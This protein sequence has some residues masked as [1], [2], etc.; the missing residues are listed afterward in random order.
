VRKFLP[1]LELV[2]FSSRLLFTACVAYSSGYQNSPNGLVRH[3]IAACHLP[4]RFSL[5]HALHHAR[6]LGARNFEGRGR[7]IHMR[8]FGWYTGYDR[9]KRCLQRLWWLLWSSGFKKSPSISP[10]LPCSEPMRWGA[11][12]APCGRSGFPLMSDA[13]SC[14]DWT[15]VRRV[16]QGSLADA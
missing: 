3:P 14:Q 12:T 5:G 9:E 2:R 1:N 15:R 6:P 16:Q 10:P 8:M 4:Q 7:R 11:S 13:P